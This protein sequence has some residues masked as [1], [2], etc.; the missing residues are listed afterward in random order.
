MTRHLFHLFCQMAALVAARKTKHGQSAKAGGQQ[1]RTYASWS[2]MITRCTNPTFPGYRLYG[3]RGIS[4]CER[5]SGT[6]GFAS[7]LEDMGER[8]AGTSLDR[9]NS[10]GHY[11]PGNCRWATPTTQARNT[12]RVVLNEAI[13]SEIRRRVAAGESIDSIASASGANR[14]TVYDVIR[15]RTWRDVA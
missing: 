6:D 3:A 12:S 1:T 13:V 9:I 2:M 4:V 14:H 15:R 10:D 5:W 8:P 7:F 11:E